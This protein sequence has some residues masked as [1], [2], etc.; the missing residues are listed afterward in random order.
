MVHAGFKMSADLQRSSTKYQ[1]RR[2]VDQSDV[3]QDRV[4]IQLRRRVE[5]TAE[6]VVEIV[7]L[8]RHADRKDGE[9]ILGRVGR[10]PGY[11][12]MLA[13]PI[14]AAKSHRTN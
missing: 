10:V 7:S 5:I 13:R 11:L 9:D 8:V 1:H 14:V 6:A 4:R 12:L 3:H 2:E